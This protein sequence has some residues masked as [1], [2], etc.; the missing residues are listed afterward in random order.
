LTLTTNLDAEQRGDLEE[1]ATAGRKLLALLRNLMDLSS[2]EAGEIRLEGRAF[3]PRRLV[4]ETM[5]LLLPRADLAGLRLSGEVG[6][7][8]P[9]LLV[10]DADRLRQVL[11]E[12]VGNGLEFTKRGEVSVCLRG[13]VEGDAF[14]LEVKVAD[15]GIGIE[16]AKQ[17]QIFDPFVQADGSLTREHG[18]AGLGL[19]VV[20][21]LVGL[22]GGTIRLDS[23]PGVGS[24]FRVRIPLA[25]A[26][27]KPVL[28]EVKTGNAEGE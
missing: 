15:T 22:M 4:A 17:R 8:V 3:C 16:E 13:T 1:V 28:A 6:D 9:A 11:L 25:I 19:T 27:E 10:G 24:T 18:G 12:L 7:E 2:L 14:H 26:S 5:A 21:S 23:H 20:R